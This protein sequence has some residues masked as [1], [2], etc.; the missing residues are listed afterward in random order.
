MRGEK[1]RCSIRGRTVC[2]VKALPPPPPHGASKAM[3]VV[4]SGNTCYAVPLSTVGCDTCG[5]AKRWVDCD[6][7]PLLWWNTISHQAYIYVHI[8]FLFFICHILWEFGGSIQI[9]QEKV[10]LRPYW[11]NTEVGSKRKEGQRRRRMK[12]PMRRVVSHADC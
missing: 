7:F 4:L 1:E 3:G 11:F 9:S 2:G 5:V 10:L 6:P 12:W 8:L